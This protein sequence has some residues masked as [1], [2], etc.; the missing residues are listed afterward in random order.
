MLYVPLRPVLFIVSAVFHTEGDVNV[1]TGEGL[2]H[3]SFSRTATEPPRAV[4]WKGPQPLQ[5]HHVS[6]SLDLYQPLGS[7]QYSSSTNGGMLERKQPR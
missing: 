2:Q 1:I 6:S 4:K 3:N 7:R 5:Q